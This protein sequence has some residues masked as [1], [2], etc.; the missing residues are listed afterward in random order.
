MHTVHILMQSDMVNFFM[1]CLTN[2]TLLSRQQNRQLKVIFV[3]K[4][5]YQEKNQ[6]NKNPNC[7]TPYLA[8]SQYYICNTASV[9]YYRNGCMPDT[10]ISTI[11]TIFQAQGTLPVVFYIRRWIKLR[12]IFS[13]SVRTLALEERMLFI[14]EG[15]EGQNLSGRTVSK[16][17]GQKSQTAA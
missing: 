4:K 13:A 8:Y 15:Q 10:H 11:I 9:S 2:A 12:T 16:R 6:P 1:T 7:F 5:A 17:T 14:L 3:P